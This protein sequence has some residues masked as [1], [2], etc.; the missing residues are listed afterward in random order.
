MIPVRELR[1]AA[2]KKDRE[3]CNITGLNAMIDIYDRNLRIS[4][5]NLGLD[6]DNA[7]IA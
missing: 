3:L 1:I 6:R 7:V 2:L 4:C 5:Q